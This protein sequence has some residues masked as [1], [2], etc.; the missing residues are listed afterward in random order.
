MKIE[1]MKNIELSQNTK[2]ICI[3]EKK[4]KKKKAKQNDTKSI[5]HLPVTLI[6]HSVLLH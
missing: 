4:K 5:F 1:Q 3:S 6:M 2:R